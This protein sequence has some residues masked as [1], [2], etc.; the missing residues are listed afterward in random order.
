MCYETSSYGCIYGC[1]NY[2]LLP[3]K[4]VNRLG[5]MHHVNVHKRCDALWDYGCIHNYLL[6]PP[7]SHFRWR[8]CQ[9]AWENARWEYRGSCSQSAWDC[10]PQAADPPVIIEN[11]SYPRNI[12]CDCVSLRI[13][14]WCMFVF[15]CVRVCARYTCTCISLLACVRMPKRKCVC[16]C[17]HV[18]TLPDVRG[19]Q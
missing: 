12:E 9:S 15:L 3:D 10:A 14:V 8:A 16:A 1:I 7:Q 17:P 5:K 4:L 11:V 13:R 6:L 19:A 2:S 18:F